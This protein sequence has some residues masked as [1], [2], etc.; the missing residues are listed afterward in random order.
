MV[1]AIYGKPTANIILSGEKLKV[2]CLRLVTR[3]EYLFSLLLF[4]RVLE[5]LATATRQEKQITKNQAGKAELQLSLFADDM[6]PYTV[7]PKDATK[8]TT[9]THQRIW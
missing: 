2:F 5:I 7:N 1:K 3:Q 9:R 8:K 4:N 6:I